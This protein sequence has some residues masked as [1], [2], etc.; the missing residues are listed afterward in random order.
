MEAAAILH[1][2]TAF[3]AWSE[4]VDSEKCGLFWSAPS[5][6][7]ARASHSAA[8]FMITARPFLFSSAG[9]SSA[10]PVPQTLSNPAVDLHASSKFNET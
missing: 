1:T 6:P 10:V 9:T 2:V 3:T 5:F 4:N 8:W 7:T